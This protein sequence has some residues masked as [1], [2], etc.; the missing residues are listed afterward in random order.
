MAGLCGLS[1]GQ[2]RQRTHRYRHR[3]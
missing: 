2:C 1:G 3:H